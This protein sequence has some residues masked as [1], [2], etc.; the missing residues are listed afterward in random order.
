MKRAG[1]GVVRHRIRSIGPSAVAVLVAI[2]VVAAW[3]SRAAAQATAAAAGNTA[4]QRQA[5]GEVAAKAFVQGQYD[6]ALAIYLDLYAQSGGRPEYLR[7]IGRC[8]QK[9]NRYDPA[10]ESFKEYL[11]KGKNLSAAEKA[12]INGFIAEVQAARMA[13][14]A[15]PPPV[16]APPAA[17]PPA[18]SPTPAPTPLSAPPPPVASAPPPA[19]VQPAPAPWASAPPPAP[20]PQPA[21]SNGLRTGGIVALVGAAV[22]AMGGTLSLIKARSTYDEG[23]GRGCKN[24]DRRAA[25]APPTPS[26]R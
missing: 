22:F 1:E 15:A 14:A 2:V 3:D 7:N 17:S 11:R 4:A 19:P 10:V 8:Q 26:T 12:E 20:A 25:R 21:P 24:A 23:L 5:R 18:V 6:E 13:S 16:V 9:L